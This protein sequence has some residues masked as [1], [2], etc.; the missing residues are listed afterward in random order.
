MIGTTAKA[1]AGKKLFMD[2]LQNSYDKN[3]RRRL[4]MTA[5]CSVHCDRAS[6]YVVEVELCRVRGFDIVSRARLSA[7]SAIG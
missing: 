4:A 6:V 1:Q 2:S 5:R 7:A 3:P